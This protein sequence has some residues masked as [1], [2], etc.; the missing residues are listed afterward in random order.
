MVQNLVFLEKL[1]K[2][3]EIM[4]NSW[5]QPTRKSQLS[6]KSVNRKLIQLYLSLFQASKIAPP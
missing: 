1:L 3:D 4:M 5:S 2:I 6:T